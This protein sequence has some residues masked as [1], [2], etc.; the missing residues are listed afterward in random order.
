MADHVA[1]MLVEIGRTLARHAVACQ[2][3]PSNAVADGMRDA[4]KAAARAV[5]E[6]ANGATGAR[7]THSVVITGPQSATV[8]VEAYD[9]RHA[10]EIAVSSIDGAC[11]GETYTCATTEGTATVRVEVAVSAVA[12][13]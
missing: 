4:Y 3:L 7:R 2:R 1:G 12:M 9:W 6:V 13:T 5:R 11:D 8:Q 10:C